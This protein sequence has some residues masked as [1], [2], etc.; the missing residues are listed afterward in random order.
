MCDA[1]T[2]TPRRA[3]KQGLP[4]DVNLIYN[5]KN[6]RNR[7]GQLFSLLALRGTL[8]IARESQDAIFRFKVDAFFV[9]PGCNQLRLIILLDSIIKIRRNRFR[10]RLHPYRLNTDFIGHDSFAGNRLCDLTGLALCFV[11]ETGTTESDGVAV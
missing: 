7:T 5:L 8:H 10:L 3:E 9:E 4:F 2:T 6:V 11:S 1:K